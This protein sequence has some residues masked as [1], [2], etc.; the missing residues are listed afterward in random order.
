MTCPPSSARTASTLATMRAQVECLERYMAGYESL[1]GIAPSAWP[2]VA[3]LTRVL[4]EDTGIYTISWP[5]EPNDRFQIRASS[6]GVCWHIVRN[7]VEAAATP[8]VITEWESPEYDDA[9]LPMYFQ[10]I[11]RPHLVTSC[12]GSPVSWPVAATC[13][14]LNGAPEGL[15]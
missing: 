7:V 10:V 11:E 6:D 5:S 2:V 13:G 1:T 8:N 3:L 15:L 4:D 12:N 9:D 14:P